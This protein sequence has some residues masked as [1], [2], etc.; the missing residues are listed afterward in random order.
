[1]HSIFTRRELRKLP[2]HIAKNKNKSNCCV[3]KTFPYRNA[4]N[5][6]YQIAV[7]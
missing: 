6:A 2:K 5:G 1:M 4:P 7:R 3:T